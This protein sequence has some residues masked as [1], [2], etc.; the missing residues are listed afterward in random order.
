MRPIY[1]TVGFSPPAISPQRAG[2]EMAK[3]E[4][5]E[6]TEHEFQAGQGKCENRHSRWQE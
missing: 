4:D 1:K 6:V 5:G 2:M 3:S